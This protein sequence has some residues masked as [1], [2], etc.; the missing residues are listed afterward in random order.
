M[1]AVFRGRMLSQEPPPASVTVTAVYDRYTYDEKRAALEDG[2][3]ALLATTPGD[4]NR[5]GS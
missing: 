4:R 3:R 2:A 5:R 1:V